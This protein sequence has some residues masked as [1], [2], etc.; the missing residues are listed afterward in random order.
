MKIHPDLCAYVHLD[1]APRLSGSSG[2]GGARAGAGTTQT[3][4]IPNTSA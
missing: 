4:G 1:V 2:G 3:A